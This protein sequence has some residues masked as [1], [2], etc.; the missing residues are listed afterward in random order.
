MKSET[1]TV[2][3]LFENRRQ[4]CVPFYQRAYVWTLEDQ[5]EQ[6]WDDIR[7]K[8]D[9]R[10]AN[11]KATPHFLGAVVLEPQPRV[12]L[13]GVDVLHIIDGQQRLTT[14]QFVLASILLTLKSPE[15]DT[16]IGIVKACFENGNPQSMRDPAVEIFKVWPTFRDRDNYK[17]ALAAPNL[18]ELR[19]RFPAHFT[20]TGELRKI[21]SDHPT[22]LAAL[23]YFSRA[24]TT[25][26]TADLEHV[27]AHVDALVNAVLHDLKVVSII[28]DPEDDAQIIFETLNGRGAQLHATDLIRNYLFM[29]AD[30]DKADPESLYD[31]LWSP[32]ET[33][34]W[35]TEQRRGRLKKPRLEWLIHTALQAELHEE[36]DLSRLYF[37]YRKYAVQGGV[38]LTAERQLLTLTEYAKHYKELIGGTGT[39][40]IARFGR[41]ISPYDITTLYPLALMISSSALPD[42]AKTE[43]FNDLVSYLVRRAVCNLTFKNYN[44]VFL[45]TL[46]QLYGDGVTPQGLRRVLGGLSGEASRWPL[47]GEFR[48]ACLTAPLFYGRLDAPKVR[49]ILTE[50]EGH[51]RS[52]VHSEE[53]TLPDLSEL[54][55]DHILPRSW[56]EHWPLP[57]TSAEPN[58]EATNASLASS[59]EAANVELLVQVGEPLNERQRSISD[60]QDS[61]NRLGNLTLL[62]LSV[63]RAAQNYAFKSKRDLLIANTNLRL[64]IPLILLES[65][66]EE[67]I[68]V[69][70][71][72]LSDAAL[73]VW[74]GPRS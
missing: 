67:A 66:D 31:T 36:V 48:S 47:D 64:N 59:S 33:E 27:S 49:S 45:T 21:G 16:Y 30:E 14:L 53:P 24:F 56:F 23:W 40:P 34:Y 44:N 7:E 4:Y 58:L 65:W 72:L 5:W 15:D 1:I 69:R 26:L 55:I 32:F 12:G 19:A 41:R 3:T 70:G 13:V 63:N 11:Q 2:R 61:V 25:W 37:E 20:R 22:A 73:I 6:L 60:R 9:A 62:N 17:R 28:L 50:L 57:K 68:K 42:D 38:P 35:A 18:D 71:G 10:L 74:P 29:R 8:A 54:D 52:T 39:T 46:R 51:L 43:M